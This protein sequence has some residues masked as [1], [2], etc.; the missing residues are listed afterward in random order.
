H[1]VNPDG[2][3]SVLVRNERDSTVTEIGRT[4]AWNWQ[5]GAMTQWVRESVV[6]NTI[7]EGMLSS[8][9]Q[10]NGPPRVI[11][12]PVQAISPRGDFFVSLNY[13][14]LHLLRPDYGYRVEVKNFQPN[15]AD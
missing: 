10:S 8:V 7:Q 13:R 6:F 3:A 9:W 4:Q 14:R 11:P 15:A 1:R 5:Q 2:F 12:W